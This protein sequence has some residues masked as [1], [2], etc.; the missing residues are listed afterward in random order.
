MA[1]A[2]MSERYGDR[3]V[4]QLAQAGG[5][6][7][8]GL[9]AVTTMKEL[10]SLGQNLSQISPES[11]D[12][13]QQLMQLGASHPFAMQDPRGQALISMGNQQHLQWKNQQ[14]A[15]QQADRQEA[16]AD[17]R[18]EASFTRL[19]KRDA[20]MHDYRM[21]EIDQRW[22]GNGE[23]GIDFS[24]GLPTKNTP[25]S[26]FTNDTLD[27]VSAANMG[28]PSMVQAEPSLFIDATSEE[29]TS[30]RAGFS[31][32]GQAMGDPN[33]KE[34]QAA[35]WER[36][37]IIQRA[38]GRPLSGKEADRLVFG[39]VN[40]ERAAAGKKGSTGVLYATEQDAID[41][42]GGT[43]LG[44]GLFLSPNGGVYKPKQ[45]TSGKWYLSSPD[46]GDMT[47]REKFEAGLKDKREARN[48]A[49][50][51][52]E[53]AAAR[54]DYNREHES[55][56]K[57]A[58]DA[59]NHFLKAKAARDI[60]VASKDTAKMKKAKEEVLAENYQRHSS[61]SKKLDDFLKKPKPK[62]ESNSG[63]AEKIIVISPGGQKGYI[64]KSQL[65]SALKRGY[66]QQ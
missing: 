45:A 26:G 47:E 18:D 52:S 31:A 60:S 27:G 7:E 5:M 33:D 12:Y 38:L 32:R 34:L 46:D 48:Y 66:K 2:A 53:E 15:M 1:I 50:R 54:A 57:S 29:P 55:L 39:P 28:D 61:A 44:D 56:K 64:P 6:I 65:E 37:D 21:K 14:F 9:K 11:P 16:R 40:R 22:G 20:S 8:N 3:L 17:R 43:A 30:P 58:Q 10:Q 51:K 13:Q 42:L 36:G 49:E 35:Y 62:S 59:E 19:G 24:G 23:G 41:A 4:G 63:S 25:V